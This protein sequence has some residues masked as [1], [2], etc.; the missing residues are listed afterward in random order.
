MFECRKSNLFSPAGTFSEVAQRYL[1]FGLFIV[2]VPGTVDGLAFPLPSFSADNIEG[3]VELA[4]NVSSAYSG[5]RSGD[6]NSAPLFGDHSLMLEI[7]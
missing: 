1:L 3:I 7:A 4:E 6:P 5:F 2:A